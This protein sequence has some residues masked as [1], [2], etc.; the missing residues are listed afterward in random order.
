VSVTQSSKYQ[1]DVLHL[2]LLIFHST[3]AH[4]RDEAA[5]NCGVGIGIH[6]STGVGLCVGEWA[7]GIRVV[8]EIFFFGEIVGDFDGFF[9]GV[10]VVG[11]LDGDDVG[12]L[13][14]EVVG[15]LEG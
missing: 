14:G 9:V 2:K 13:D 5:H 15:G 6:K 10:D 11:C 4:P 12:I 8:G 3:H 7:V 1:V